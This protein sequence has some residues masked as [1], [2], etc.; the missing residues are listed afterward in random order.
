[1]SFVIFIYSRFVHLPNTNR[2]G[3]ARV[4]RS[5]AEQMY[6]FGLQVQR[7]NSNHNKWK[8]NNEQDRSNETAER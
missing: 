8:N 5:Q 7:H 3:I 1:M 6:A 2:S 4:H